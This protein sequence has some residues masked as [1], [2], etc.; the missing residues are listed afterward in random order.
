MRLFPLPK[1]QMQGLAVCQGLEIYLHQAVKADPVDVMTQERFQRCIACRVTRVVNYRYLGIVDIRGEQG[2]FNIGGCAVQVEVA[3]AGAWVEIGG[4][5]D[6]RD[7]CTGLC[8]ARGKDRIQII[9]QYY[10]VDGGVKWD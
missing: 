7:G 2:G 8:V 3:A 4:V 6:R 1:Q 10:P 5:G 9:D